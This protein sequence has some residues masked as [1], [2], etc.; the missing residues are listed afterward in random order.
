MTSIGLWKN[1]VYKFRDYPPAII[2]FLKKYF[3]YNFVCDSY[4]KFYDN[5]TFLDPAQTIS[6]IIEHDKSIVRFGD[7]AIDMVHGIGLYYD[8]WHQKYDAKLA[9]RY[10]E[11]LNSRHP[12]LLV[13]FNPQ[14]FLKTK[15]ELVNVGMPYHFWTNSKVFLKDYLH[16]DLVYGTALCFQPRF[17]PN[18]NFEQ[19][20]KYFRNKNIIIVTSNT[21]RFR[22][23]HLGKTTD[24]IDCPRCDVWLHYDEIYKQTLRLVE[25]NKY[26]KKDVLFLVSLACTA[27]VMTYDLTLEGYQAWDTGQ[28]FDLAFREISKM[29][30]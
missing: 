16:K 12:R 9:E 30:S 24:F 14:F 11:V 21:K 6:N 8:D 28:F 7:E 25:D 26:K 3:Y 13:A 29:S 4:L 1:R 22:E 10:K 15:K 20:H 18:I 2:P 27:K 5:F 19:L 23:I 17:N